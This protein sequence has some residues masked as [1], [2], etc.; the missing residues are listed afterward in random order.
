MRWSNVCSCVC[1][2]LLQAAA[3]TLECQPAVFSLKHSDSLILC[4]SNLKA[5]S[6]ISHCYRTKHI[7]L[8][9]QERKGFLFHNYYITDDSRLYKNYKEICLLLKHPS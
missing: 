8:C 3:S 4:G 6:K 1:T 7:F 9:W 5:K 2:F